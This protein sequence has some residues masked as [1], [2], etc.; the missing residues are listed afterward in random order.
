MR[1][2]GKKMIQKWRND[3]PKT[4]INELRGFL[5][6]LKYDS[7]V[8]PVFDVFIREKDL[9]NK[10]VITDLSELGVWEQYAPVDKPEDTEYLDGIFYI[11]VSDLNAENEIRN[12]ILSEDAAWLQEYPDK[13]GYL[14]Q[15]VS[16]R[17][18]E[19]FRFLITDQSKGVV[20]V[21]T[22]AVGN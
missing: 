2:G 4:K 9:N 21:V 18:Y 20:I 14:R 16:V 10:V 19:K 11:R 17:I 12:K 3:C 15:K 13:D 8:I 22:K 1:V 7:R 5:G 6:V